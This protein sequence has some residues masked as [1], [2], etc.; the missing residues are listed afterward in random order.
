MTGEFYSICI[1]NGRGMME[2]G[3]VFKRVPSEPAK[4]R[5]IH[6]SVWSNF[7]RQFGSNISRIQFSKV[8]A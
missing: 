7:W 4:Y 8:T 6:Q 3:L 1:E 5:E 2:I